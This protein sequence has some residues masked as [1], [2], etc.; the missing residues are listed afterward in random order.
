MLGAKLMMLC[1][2][3]KEGHMSGVLLAPGLE[4]FPWSQGCGA[5]RVLE[6]ATEAARSWPRRGHRKATGNPSIGLHWPE[7]ERVT[8]FPAFDNRQI[9]TDQGPPPR[10]PCTQSSNTHLHL[11]PLGLSTHPL[12]MGS[13]SWRQHESPE[14]MLAASRGHHRN[15]RLG[16]GHWSFCHWHQGWPFPGLPEDTGRAL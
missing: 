12:C 6:L 1:E 4:R 15:P 2:P 14:T 11:P 8:S 9:L 13:Q 16:L 7:R 5:W 3:E 10:P